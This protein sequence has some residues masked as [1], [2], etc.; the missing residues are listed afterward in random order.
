[1]LEYMDIDNLFAGTIVWFYDNDKVVWIPIQT[2]QKL[3]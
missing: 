1:M 2:W 3:K